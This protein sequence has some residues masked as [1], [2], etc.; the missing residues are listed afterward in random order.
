MLQHD[1]FVPGTDCA[2]HGWV[3][4]GLKLGQVK[5]CQ[6]N[7]GILQAMP[8]EQGPPVVLTK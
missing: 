3:L 1:C 6:D 8:F 2:W 4:E 7:D 5:R